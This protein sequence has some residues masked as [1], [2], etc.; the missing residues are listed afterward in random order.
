MSFVTPITLAANG[1]RLVPLG[2][3]H[4]SDLQRVT[5]DG[6]LWKIRVTGVPAPDDV[7][8]YIQ[9]DLDG[10][11][12]QDLIISSLVWSDEHPEAILQILINENGKFVDETDSRLFNFITASASAHR[13]VVKDVNGDGAPDII[14]E[15]GGTNRGDESLNDITNWTGSTRVLLNDG[16][17]YF[18]T[19]INQQVNVVDDWYRPLSQPHSE[20]LDGKLSFSNLV[21]EIDVR[22]PAIILRKVELKDVL[23]T[24]PYGIDPKY[25]GVSEYNEFYYLRNNPDVA[26]AISKGEYLTGL[27]H[28]IKFGAREG[29][30]AT[31]VK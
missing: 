24:G 31:A 6:E 28:Y 14:T 13:F 23:S 5:A 18:A 15:G 7:R 11:G 9:A 29:R 25:W 27:E 30:K 2:F 8:A 10:D 3:E 16:A 17:G 21:L 22:F 19:V 26:D 1:I 12:D 4:E 20:S